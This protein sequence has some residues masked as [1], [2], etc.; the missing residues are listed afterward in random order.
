MHII[1]IDDCNLIVIAK[2][3]LHYNVWAY[4]VC[5]GG[6]WGCVWLCVCGMCVGVCV[7]CVDVAYVVW[8]V[9]GGCVV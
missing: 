4:V 1:F 7:V 8:C 6:L 5:M 2:Q 9:C 3:M